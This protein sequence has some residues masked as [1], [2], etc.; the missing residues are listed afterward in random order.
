MNV[1][2]AEDQYVIT[3]DHKQI[4][5]LLAGAPE[6][7]GPRPEVKERAVRKLGK[8]LL[9]WCQSFCALELSDDV[10]PQNDENR[11]SI[12]VLHSCR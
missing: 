4:A 11:W 2:V 10:L 1:F 9:G 5:E 3:A 12:S 7:I 6:N 8:S